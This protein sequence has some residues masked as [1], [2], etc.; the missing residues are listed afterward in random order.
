MFHFL[1]VWHNL[2]FTFSKIRWRG[3]LKYPENYL[4]WLKVPSAPMAWPPG[5]TKRNALPI[6]CNSLCICAWAPQ[7]WL[8][9]LLPLTHCWPS[10][11]Q[12]VTGQNEG[13]AL[14]EVATVEDW[15]GLHR[16]IQHW[17]EFR[18]SSRD[19]CFLKPWGWLFSIFQIVLH[20]LLGQSPESRLVGLSEI[21]YNGCL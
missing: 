1:W 10:R 13:K 20:I 8:C 5:A 6:R 9:S 15:T 18:S 7:S 17:R 16:E 2:F 3:L 11:V 4:T 19:L 21:V 12:P 14:G